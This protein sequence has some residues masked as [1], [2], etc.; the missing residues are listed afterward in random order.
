MKIYLIDG[1]NLIHKIKDLSVLQNKDRQSAREKLAHRLDSYFTN[2]KVNVTLFYDGFAGVPVNTSKIKIVYSEN[3]SA[4]DKIRSSIEK[5]KNPKNI[6][7]V[8]SDGEIRKIARACSCELI[9]SSEFDRVIRQ[10][11]N[12]DEEER[13][14][15]E[16]KNSNEE[17]KKLF[18]S[19]D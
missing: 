4:D 13:K 16:I 17:F 15:S 14:I 11:E 3:S 8:T 6:I 18:G 9:T 5:A 7:V 2:K 19:D 12:D 10:R 1:N